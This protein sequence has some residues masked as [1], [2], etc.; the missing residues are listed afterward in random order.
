MHTIVDK[1]KQTQNEVHSAN[2]ILYVMAIFGFI[3]YKEF[4]KRYVSLK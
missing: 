3:I 2:I 4:G 1:A